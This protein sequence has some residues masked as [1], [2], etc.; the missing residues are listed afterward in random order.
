MIK[1]LL[2]SLSFTV[3]M[4]SHQDSV[5][6]TEI[7]KYQQE[8]NKDYLDEYRSPLTKKARK[9]FQGH[10]FFP[11][12]KAYQVKAEVI[13]TPESKPFLMAMSTGSNQLYRRLAILRFN[14]NGE[15]YELEAY[16]KARSFGL[17]MKT[18][19]VLIPIIDKTTGE[20][21]YDGGRYLTFSKAPEGDEWILD[22]NKLFNPYCAYNDEITCPVVPE[23]NH[24][25]V[26]IEAGIKGF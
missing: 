19:S 13:K 20:S 16:T 18:T 5:Y 9:S 12:N 22:F 8:L 1:V 7:Q 10:E 4:C 3:L 17:S 24:L 26:A 2:I 11:I 15:P 21:T 14:L 6:I 23:V 25:S